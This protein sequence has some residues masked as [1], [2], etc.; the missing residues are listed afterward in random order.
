MD[1]GF[2]TNPSFPTVP[3]DPGTG[4]VCMGSS[5]RHHHQIY[6][7]ND[8]EPEIRF[9]TPVLLPQQGY[10]HLSNSATRKARL[11][12]EKIHVRMLCTETLRR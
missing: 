4:N 7:T 6:L 11:W 5:S 1:Y 9:V 10:K 2:C 8:Q 12:Q 3:A